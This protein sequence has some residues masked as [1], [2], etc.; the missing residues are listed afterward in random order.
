MAGHLFRALVLTLLSVLLVRHITA[1]FHHCFTRLT[2]ASWWM[3]AFLGTRGRQ[4]AC[5]ASRSHGEQIGRSLKVN[6]PA[7]QGG[8]LL[9]PLTSLPL[10]LSHRCAQE[11]VSGPR[12]TWG[13]PSP[14]APETEMLSDPLVWQWRSQEGRSLPCENG[15]PQTWE[16]CAFWFSKWKDFS[17]GGKREVWKGDSRKRLN[18]L[19]KIQ[20]PRKAD[21][22]SGANYNIVSI[23]ED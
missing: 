1:H 21:Q 13:S 2:V 8:A 20:F 7:G 18:L 14:G 5:C 15:W 12:G 19:K 23:S 4:H 22:N 10:P 3:E 6:T 16:F 11:T 9:S 17:L